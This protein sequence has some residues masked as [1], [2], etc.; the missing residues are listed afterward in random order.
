[1][2][3]AL[4]LTEVRIVPLRNPPPRDP[5][6]ATTEQRLEMIT[7][8][9][10]DEPKFRL[11]T[12]EIEREGES[13]TVRTLRSLREEIGETPIFLIIGSDAFRDFPTWHEP[14]EILQ[15]AHIVVMQRPGA[16]HPDLYPERITTSMDE[17]TSTPTGHIWM[18]Q[19]SQLEISATKIRELLQQG[20]S[21]LYLLPAPVLEIIEQQG[22]YRP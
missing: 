22:I 2:Q 10:A 15:L 19:V 3:Q 1:V 14:G 12:Q 17:L 16:E 13:Y 9:I 5:P 11:D 21:P 6:I 8:A 4:G 7:A 20:K 18:Q